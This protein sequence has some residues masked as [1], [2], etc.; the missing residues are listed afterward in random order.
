MSA[1]PLRLTRRG[2]VLSMAMACAVVA[3][4]G[5]GQSQPTTAPS[6]PV[7]APAVLAPA[8]KLMIDYFLP[9]PI[10]SPLTKDVWGNP[11]VL[12]R[13]EDNGLESHGRLAKFCYWDGQIIKAKDGKYHMFASRWPESGGH[14]AWGGSLAIHAVSNNLLGPYEDKGPMWP[15]DQ[16]GKGH[17]VTAL[18]LPGDEGYA[19]VISETRPGEVWT[20]KDLNGPYTYK[21]KMSGVQTSNISII[22]RPDGDFEIVPRNGQIYISKKAD[23]I[24]G[25]YK[26]QGPSVFPRGIPNLEDPALFYAG[27]LYHITVNSWSTRKA[28]HLTSEDGISNWKNRGLAYNPDADSVKYTDATINH[29]SLME[30]PA[31]YMEDGVVRA[32][33]MAVL[34]VPKNEERG[35]DIHASKVIVIPFDGEGF[36]KGPCEAVRRGKSCGHRT[37]VIEL[38]DGRALAARARVATSAIGGTRTENRLFLPPLYRRGRTQRGVL[39]YLGLVPP[40]F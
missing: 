13:D 7:P 16:G 33:T 37:P 30:R 27:G 10:I 28:Y 19:I 9:T 8:P 4:I 11:N 40:R 34:D 17:N 29:W 32:Y 20:C 21:G 5:F 6:H 18:Q 24:L 14:N 25:P 36:N 39:D 15:N 1:I 3:S 31:P 26:S 22:I 12:P 23:G 35:N 38:G 2:A